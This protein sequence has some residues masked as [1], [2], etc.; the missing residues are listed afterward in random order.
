MF[1]NTVKLTGGPDKSMGKLLVEMYGENHRFCSD[2]LGEAEVNVICKELGY[3]YVWSTGIIRK[4]LC[5]QVH[6]IYFS[7]LQR[8]WL[9]ICMVYSSI[10]AQIDSW[11]LLHVY[12]FYNESVFQFG[13]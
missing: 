13:E 11:I 4:E 6:N 1:L 7:Y 10:F 2:N 12:N 8:T 3:R 9:Q 5:L